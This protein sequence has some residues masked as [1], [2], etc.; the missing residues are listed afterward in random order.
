MALYTS[1][2]ADYY[3]ILLSAMAIIGLKKMNIR[4]IIKVMFCNKSILAYSA[5]YLLFYYDCFFTT[6]G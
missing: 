6:N 3:I 1:V 4:N 2:K 5:F